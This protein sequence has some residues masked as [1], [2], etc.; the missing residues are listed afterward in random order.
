MR[1]ITFSVSLQT[2]F[3]TCFRVSIRRSGLSLSSSEFVNDLEIDRYIGLIFQL[4][5]QKRGSDGRFWQRTKA[6]GYPKTAEVGFS[7]ISYS[8]ACPFWK[9]GEQS[10]LSLAMGQAK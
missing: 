6:R 9:A 1:L 2:N 3:L 5:S 10:M 7:G 4:I 8:N